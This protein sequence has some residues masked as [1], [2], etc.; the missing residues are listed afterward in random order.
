MYYV[1]A[2]IHGHYNAYAAMLERIALKSDDT[3]YILGDVI[4]RG[5]DGVRILQDMMTK[6]NVVPILGNHEF[7]AAICLPWLLQEITE[8]SLSRLDET[9][10]AALQEWIYNG[11]RPTIQALKALEP[12]ERWEILDY[13]REMDIYETVDV[14]GQSYLLT[15]AGLDH[16]ALDKS[17]ENYELTDFLFCRP[18]PE[19]EFYPDRYLVYGHTP[20]RMLRQQMG[21][22]PTDNILCR[23]TQIAIDCG[24][25]FGIQLGCLCLDTGE[26][27]Y[28]RADDVQK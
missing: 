23:G 6:S 18:G 24:C 20:T 7:T 13:L 3:L 22:E 1:C 15:H 10:L 4:D 28:V 27:F 21:V 8:Q 11:G 19:Q 16:F 12:E 14:G 2:D 25:G 26:E 5:P 9:Q 17:L